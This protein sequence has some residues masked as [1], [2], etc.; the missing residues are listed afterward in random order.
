MRWLALPVA[1][2]LLSAPA[3][4]HEV[5]PGVTGFAGLMLHP[6]LLPEQAMCLAGFLLVT[7]RMAREDFLVAFTAML[8]GLAIGKALNIAAPGLSTFWY[9]PAVLAL[10][11]GLSV[12]T[13]ARIRAVL[14]V[15]LVFLL[16]FFLSVAIVPETPTMNGVYTAVFAAM[17]TSTIAMLLVGYPLTYVKSRW[18]GILIRVGGA[19]LAAIAA[20]FLAFAI[21]M[22]MNGSI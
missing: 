14:G 19:W 18:G 20:L 21:R 6:I 5:V 7:G 4:A 22:I 12:A 9:M 1:Y 8:A 11:A 13:F 3:L 10:I 15:F 17:A 16:S 2:L